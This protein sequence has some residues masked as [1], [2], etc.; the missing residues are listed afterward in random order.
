LVS[1]TASLVIIILLYTTILIR[2]YREG[3][4]WNISATTTWYIIISIINL[5]ALAWRGN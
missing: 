5:F 4:K 3:K 2:G 1:G